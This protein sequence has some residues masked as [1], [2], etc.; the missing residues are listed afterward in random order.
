MG[1]ANQSLTPGRTSLL[2]AVNVLLENIGE[3]P[4]ETL[5]NEQVAEARIAERTLLEFH[6]EGQSRGW[7]WNS[8]T[9]LPLCQGHH[10]QHGD[11]AGKCGPL[12]AGSVS[13]GRA[14]PAARPEGL[15]PGEAQ[16]SAGL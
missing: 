16:L 4:V 6:K 9:R 15:R 11:R 1:T 5:E 13:V 12:V 3:A 2:E 7:A 14:I 10:N 8:E